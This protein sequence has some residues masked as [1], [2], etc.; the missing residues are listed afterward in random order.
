MR[1]DQSKSGAF[2]PPIANENTF[3]RPVP[4][5]RQL[6]LPHGHRGHQQHLQLPGH[7]GLAIL[8]GQERLPIHAGFCHLS[9][10]LEWR[11]VSL[12]PM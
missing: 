11:I 8:E 5:A 12:S 9:S 2:F 6:R 1:I 3:S 10:E 4:L 7:R